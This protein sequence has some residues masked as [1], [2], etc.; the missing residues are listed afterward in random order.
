MQPVVDNW[1][2]SRVKMPE[3]YKSHIL[4]VNGIDIGLLPIVRLSSFGKFT[5]TAGTLKKL[6]SFNKTIFRFSSLMNESGMDFKR[7]SNT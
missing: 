7:L 4:C 5:S 2:E 1:S 6:L 3:V